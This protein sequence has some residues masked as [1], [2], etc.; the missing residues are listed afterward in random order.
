MNR[1]VVIDEDVVPPG[2]RLAEVVVVTDGDRMF[3][4]P[5]RLVINGTEVGFAGPVS[6]TL[7]ADHVMVL[8]VSL[9]VASVR[10]I[11]EADLASMVPLHGPVS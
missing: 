9:Q 3:E 1:A 8:M 4:L 7:A 10:F 11:S 5:T 2:P 6:I